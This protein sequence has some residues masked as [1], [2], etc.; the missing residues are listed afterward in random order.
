M[1]TV[2]PIN[3]LY[4]EDDGCHLQIKATIHNKSARLLID[5][6]ASKT[7]FD[8]TRIQRFVDKQEFR[9][10]D[11]LSTGLGTNSMETHGV[12]LK[13]IKLGTLTIEHYEAILLDLT[14][15]NDS[16][17]GINFPPIDGVLGS[18]IMLQYN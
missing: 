12:T 2:I 16:Y 13:H 15:V 14:H 4:I 10:M 6:G 11:K 9:D 8:K 18:D 5:T 3:I 7:V 1:T 17:E